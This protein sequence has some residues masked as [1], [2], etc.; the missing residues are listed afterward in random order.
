MGESGLKLIKLADL[1]FEMGKLN[2]IKLTQLIIVFPI[3]WLLF[4][5]T[6]DTKPGFTL[7]SENL[8]PINSIT[9]LK[10]SDVSSSGNIYYVAPYGASKASG[11]LTDPFKSIQIGMDKLQPGD[12]LYLR[13]GI[14]SLDNK[15]WFNRSGTP[16]KPI[17]IR[18]YPGEN[19][20]LDGNGTLDHIVLLQKSKWLIIEGITLQN[21]GGTYGNG[22]SL[23]GSTDIELHN[24]SVRQVPHSGI[25][26][27]SLTERVNIFN[28][29]ISKAA[30]G[31]ELHGSNLVVDSCKSHDNNRMINNG[32]DCDDNPATSGDYGGIAFE[33][34][35]TPGPV[36]IRNS[37]GWNNKASS[38]CYTIDGSFVEIYN[39]Q[40]I[41]IHDNISRDGVATFETSGDTTGIKIFRNQVWN[42]DFLTLHQSNKMLI[43]NNTVW[44]MKSAIWFGKGDKYG[45]GSTEGLVFVNNIIS[46]SGIFLN[47]L[48]NFA[49]S[50]TVNN[51]IYFPMTNNQPVFSTFKGLAQPNLLEWAKVTHLDSNSQSADPL[52]V[53]AANLDFHLKASSPA[54]NRG[55]Q[56]VNNTTNTSAKNPDI[57][58][59]EFSSNVYV[60]IGGSV[61]NKTVIANT[62]HR[63]IAVIK[64]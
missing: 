7:F 33:V 57:G 30:I 46:S 34:I 10:T 6:V 62:T 38:I 9:S 32:A 48:Q 44:N 55:L 45:N 36:E 47:I 20:I 61:Y 16:D 37:S 29:E 43:S 41:S 13:G 63:I 17:M 1:G 2:I 42:E 19:P 35:N 52:F 49:A 21:A 50:T 24:I 58:A 22:F 40:N 27:D 12:T 60:K 59:F 8:N 53:D 14:Y 18:N 51:N 56:I 11:T 5:K 15:I 26:L 31:V 25:Y 3:F 54:I 39:A 23:L 4:Q 28:C 64:N